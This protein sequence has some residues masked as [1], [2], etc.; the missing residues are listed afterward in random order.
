MRAFLHVLNIWVGCLFVMATLG[1]G[2]PPSLPNQSLSPPKFDVEKLTEGFA[3]AVKM[4]FLPDG[5]SLVT[6]KET[7]R[8]RLVNPD[9]TLQ[10]QPVVDVAVNYLKERGL[11]GIAAHPAVSQNG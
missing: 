8:V 2:T 9:F 6:E 1:C 10:P 3:F 4:A 5:R 7:G 11:M